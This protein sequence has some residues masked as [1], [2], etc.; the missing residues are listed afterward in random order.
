MINTS[1]YRL[2]IIV[3]AVLALGC[4]Q[5]TPT[6]TLQTGQQA[7]W[8]PKPNPPFFSTWITANRPHSSPSNFKQ[9]ASCAM[10]PKNK[11]QPMSWPQF[12][13]AIPKI[14]RPDSKKASYEA[15]F[16]LLTA[17]EIHP[18]EFIFTSEV[19]SSQYGQ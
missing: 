2:A 14:K 6:T 15:G 19:T 13:N 18:R 17:T 12:R 5:P 1:A 16:G 10:A 9:L 3:W 7:W 4:S 8:N 11:L